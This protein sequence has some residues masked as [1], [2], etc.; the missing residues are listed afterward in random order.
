M[1]IKKANIL[2]VLFIVWLIFLIWGMLSTIL[3]NEEFFIYNLTNI[4]AM[5]FTIL[6]IFYFFI[7]PNK[8]YQEYYK[9]K[10]KFFLLISFIITIPLLTK[11]FFERSVPILLHSLSNTSSEKIVII[12]KKSIG[13]R[14]CRNKIS[15]EGYISFLNGDICNL[16]QEFYSSIEVGNKL[17]IFGKSSIFGFTIEKVVINR[18]NN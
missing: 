1:T 2:G 13:G 16:S 6:S 10:N 9:G 11:I 8:F 14:M 4:L 5:I 7:K 12:S 3:V 17:R 18:K 15:L